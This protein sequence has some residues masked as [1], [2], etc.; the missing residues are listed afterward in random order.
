M[1]NTASGDDDG[2]DTS[3]LDDLSCLEIQN[4]AIFNDA[5]ASEL[6]ASLPEYEGTEIEDAAEETGGQSKDRHSKMTRLLE[7]FGKSVSSV[8]CVSDFQELCVGAEPAHAEFMRMVKVRS[9]LLQRIHVAYSRKFNTSKASKTGG[10]EE[11]FL[12]SS[13]KGGAGFDNPDALLTGAVRLVCP[14]P[15]RVITST[16]VSFTLQRPPSRCLFLSW[17]ASARRTL[18]S[19]NSSRRPCRICWAAARRWLSH[20]YGAARIVLL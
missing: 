8:P 19:S 12:R 4:S 13:R 17:P 11:R 18:C 2:K 15:Y 20:R 3:G 10:V 14:V 16:S 6:Y 9:R 5:Y 1:G 7:V